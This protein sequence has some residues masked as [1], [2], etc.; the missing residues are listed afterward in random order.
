MLEEEALEYLL[1][2]SIE[3]NVDIWGVGSDMTVDYSPELIESLEYPT[4]SDMGVCG[5]DS[6][7]YG[8]Q[9]KL[10]RTKSDKAKPKSDKSAKNK[11]GNYNA[12]LYTEYTVEDS[13]V[14]AELKNA[15]IEGVY[16]S[17]NAEVKVNKSNNKSDYKNIVN[18]VKA[19]YNKEMQESRSSMSY[20]P[21]YDSPKK[22]AYKAEISRWKESLDDVDGGVFT[23]TCAFVGKLILIIIDMFL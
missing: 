20:T 23:K 21:S 14:D 1:D 5:G 22:Q 10:K 4:A 15:G 16:E 12:D 11:S 6:L 8:N 17:Y 18:A 9:G 3:T 2:S 19:A 7:P 13:F